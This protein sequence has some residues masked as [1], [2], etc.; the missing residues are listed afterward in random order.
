MYGARSSS[1]S[2]TTRDGFKNWLMASR[3]IVGMAASR[4]T[5]RT[6]GPYRTV[7]RPTL[8]RELTALGAV[9]GPVLYLVVP[10]LDLALA[11]LLGGTVAYAVARRAKAIT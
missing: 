9:L 1:Y 8:G 11:G 3:G 6:C 10:G 5:I 4:S 7:G 2:P